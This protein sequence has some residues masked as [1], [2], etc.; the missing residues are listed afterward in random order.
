MRPR[1]EKWRWIL[2]SILL[3]CLFARSST[4]SPGAQVNFMG[5][6]ISNQSSSMPDNYISQK[7]DSPNTSTSTES[8]GAKS[9][10]HRNTEYKLYKKYLPPDQYFE[11]Q[12]NFIQYSKQLRVSIQATSLYIKD[13]TL[14]SLHSNSP[15]APSFPI[16]FLIF[17]II[18]I[19]F[20][21][22]RNN[23]KIK[24]IC[25]WRFSFQ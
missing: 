22:F 17:L 11:I 8:Q 15:P 7:N 25:Y 14:R 24:N 2:I 18:L 20:G 5:I 21:V 19:R 4:C 9:N 12:E 1:K 13:L 16:L 10:P 3:L 6:L 23:E